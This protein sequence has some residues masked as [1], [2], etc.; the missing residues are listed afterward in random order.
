MTRDFGF[1]AHQAA[2]DRLDQL[3]EALYAA[4]EGLD[5]ADGADAGLFCGCQTCVVRET[6]EAAW[7][8]LRQAAYEEFCREPHP[9]ATAAVLFSIE[10]APGLPDDLHAFGPYPTHR[11]AVAVQE[12]IL[13]DRDAGQNFVSEAIA[14]GRHVATEVLTLVNFECEGSR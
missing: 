2:E 3:G 1:E 9:E 13:R 8:L 7:P 12:Q 10:T 4:E 6:L 11:N 14:Q 5:G